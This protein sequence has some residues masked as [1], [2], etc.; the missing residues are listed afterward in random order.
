MTLY[1]SVYTLKW[2]NNSDFSEHTFSVSIDESTTETGTNTEY[3]NI[4]LSLKLPALDTVFRAEICE[5]AIA[6]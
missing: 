1:T 2:S 6:F 5:I 3:S 4:S